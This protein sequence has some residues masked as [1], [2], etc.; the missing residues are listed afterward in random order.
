MYFRTQIN[1]VEARTIPTSIIPVVENKEMI[2]L[3][4]VFKSQTILDTID[5]FL[6]QN[7]HLE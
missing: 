2:D 1:N 7:P 4:I 5:I 6:K 3:G